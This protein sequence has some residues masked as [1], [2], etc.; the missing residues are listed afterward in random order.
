M[1]K[2]NGTLSKDLP[3]GRVVVPEG[4]EKKS[5][6]KYYL[7]PMEDVSEEQKGKIRANIFKK[8]E[9]LEIADRT[10]IQEVN[11]FPAEPGYYR[12]KAGGALSC[13]NVKTPDI[14]KESFAWWADWHGLGHLRYAIWDPEDHYGIEI[15][16][17]K[18]RL[19]D[20]SIPV[21]E[22]I[23]T[24]EHQVLE[25]FVGDEPGFLQMNFIS[26]WECGYDQLLS[27]TDRWLYGICANAL[28]DGKIPVFA[29]EI[30]CKGADGVNE[31]RSRFW[32]GYHREADGTFKCKI[33]RFIKVP[34]ETVHRLVMH[35]FREFTHLNKVLPRIYEENK[36][37]WTE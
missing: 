27:G 35:N 19:T 10:R 14:S 24:T 9:G 25:S 36:D 32:I 8:G 7:E 22:R 1:A 17:N 37:N 30:L 26:P 34:T 5:Y 33:P 13:A 16:K 28:I 11:A 29:T 12:L 15:T 31:I 4:S 23:W 21:G 6:Y 2:Y 3:G 20:S 18:E